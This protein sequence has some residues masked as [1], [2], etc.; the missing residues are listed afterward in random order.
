MVPPS[1]RGGRL[2]EEVGDLLF[3]ASNLARYLGSDP[4]SCL[5]R[6]NHKFNDR[7]RALEHEVA[8]LGK[9]VRDCAPEELDRLWN[10]VKSQERARSKS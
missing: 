6:A 5:R 8:K 9:R 7:F 2:E 3:A 4:E 1:T 10:A